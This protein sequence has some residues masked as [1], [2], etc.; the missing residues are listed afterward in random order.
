MNFRIY[1]GLYTNTR[2]KLAGVFLWIDII[3]SL[4]LPPRPPTRKT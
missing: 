4:R 1:K 2:E 3:Q